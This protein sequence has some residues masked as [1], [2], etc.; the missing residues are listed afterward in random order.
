MLSANWT[1]TRVVVH[2][3]HNFPGVDREICVIE[4]PIEL[5]FCDWL[6]GRVVVGCEVWV[7]ES[8]RRL[9]ALL[10]VEDEHA[11]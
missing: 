9:D 6:V 5:L 7:G 3:H 2:S 8:L 10:G 4:R 1:E 11:L